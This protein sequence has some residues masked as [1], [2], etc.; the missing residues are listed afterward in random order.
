MPFRIPTLAELAQRTANAFRANL[1]GSDARLW[2][3]NVAVSAKV[4]AGA[5][6]EPFA[7]LEY[8]SRQSV[9]HLAEGPWL[10]RH[11]YDYGLARLPATF[12]EGRVTI[13]GDANVTVPG[14]LVLQRADGVA[15]ELPAGGAPRGLGRV[16][17]PA[18]CLTAGRAG[19]A[20][21]GVV[22]TLTAPVDRLQRE[23]QVAAAGIGLGADLESDESL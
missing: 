10:E 12:A 20:A 9:K 11:A 22:L 3:N 14:G 23:H 5:V 1:K 8:I 7:F 18:R 4:I 2:P 6:W 15:D 13:S 17:L 19:N 16:D 21:A